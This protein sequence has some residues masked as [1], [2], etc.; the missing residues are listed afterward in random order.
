MTENYSA[1]APK[2]NLHRRSQTNTGKT[3]PGAFRQNF[4][5]KFVKIRRAKL[6]V[7]SLWLD[8]QRVFVFGCP[9]RFDFCGL[10]AGF[11]GILRVL[12]LGGLNL[13]VF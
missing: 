12:S 4:R 3:E 1:N 11:P 9:F 8:K 6:L 2:S 13:G 10:F 5:G 7:C